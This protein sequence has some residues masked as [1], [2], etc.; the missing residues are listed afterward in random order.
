MSKNSEVYNEASA[1]SKRQAR[2]NLRRLD[3]ELGAATQS[4]HFTIRSFRNMNMRN[5]RLQTHANTRASGHGGHED[6]AETP[7]FIL[8]NNEPVAGRSEA[9]VGLLRRR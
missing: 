3:N 1:E 9:I 4:V 8:E 2:L 7:H 5:S 6:L